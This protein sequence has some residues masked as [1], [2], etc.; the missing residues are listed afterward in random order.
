L[1]SYISFPAKRVEDGQASAATPAL[2]TPFTFAKASKRRSMST[3]DTQAA[4]RSVKKIHC[5]QH[6][7]FP[8]NGKQIF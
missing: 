7:A 6:V 1:H 4:T 5:C 8:G 3:E 2:V